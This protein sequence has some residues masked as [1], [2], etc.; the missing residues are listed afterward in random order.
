[1]EWFKHSTGSHEDPDISD[2]WD[3]FGDAGPV[4]FWTI[5][6]VFGVE[7][8]H[9]KDGWLTLSVPYFERKLRRKYKKVEK[10]LEFYEKRERILFQKSDLE[11]SITIPK[12]I[13]IASNWTV[14]PKEETLPPPTELPTEEPTAKEE[15]KNKKRIERNNKAADAPFVLPDWIPEETW[16]SY[17]AVR[18]KKRAADTTYAL[19]LVIAELLKIKEKHNHD[20]VAVLNKSII[21]GW[22][23][24]YP[25]KELLGDS[26][27]KSSFNRGNF[28]AGHDQGG[29]GIPPEYKPEPRVLPS[30]EEIERGQAQL[31]KIKNKIAGIEDQ[32]EEGR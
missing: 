8:S 29:L 32:N 18:K 22:S 10:I 23:D 15:K 9:L 27:G 3:T 20:P 21:S 17:M 25:I 6:E 7:Y 5:L 4:V 19:N 26:N 11:I 13:K 28:K 12:F 16:K 31:R 14:R 30:P 1:M 24:V 2:A